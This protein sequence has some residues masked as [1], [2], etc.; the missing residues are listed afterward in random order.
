IVLWAA[1]HAAGLHATLAGVILAACIPARPPADYA[2]L[3]RQADAILT[4]E[5]RHR[6]EQL[7]YGPSEPALRALEAINDRLM[8]PTE[9]LLRT[10]FPQSSF[11]V[12]PLFALANAGVELTGDVFAGH[13]ALMLAIGAGLVVGKPVGFLLTALLA[14]RLGAAVK[15][16]AY[17]WRQLAGAGA[18]AGIGFTMA[19]F[20]AGQA[21]ALDTEFAAA[22]VAV[23]A[24]SLVSALI[25][26]L[27]LWKPAAEEAIDQEPSLS[28]G[29]ELS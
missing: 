14:V 29:T 6:E 5:A 18:L 9:R 17:S 10:V 20:I 3:A 25:G 4:D 13:E 16:Q 22:K 26:V 11:V 2:T 19:L 28:A 27:L 24:A 21:Y 12:L 7:R 23:F 1:V 15:P 8:S